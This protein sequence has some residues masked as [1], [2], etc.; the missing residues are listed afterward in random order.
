MRDGFLVIDADRHI[1]E[2]ADLWDRYMDPPFRGRVQIL[3]PGQGRR[4]VDGELVS[5]AFRLPGE[6]DTR[7]YEQYNKIFSGD[8]H[9]RSVFGEALDADFD[10]PSNLRDMDREGV[11][12][13]VLF[14]TM[15]LYII[16]KSDM[17]PQ[18]SA[19]ICR[20][21]NNWLSEYCSHDP[22]RL[23]GVMLIPLQD[24]RLAVE[25]LRRASNELGL[26]GIFWRPN[27]RSEEHTSELQ[28]RQYLVCR[29]L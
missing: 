29:L 19:A 18:V 2:P 23:K 4:L 6:G 16:W 25:E 13:S 14:P 22:T 3:G 1:I 27:P 5:D 28:S 17:D 9:Y 24:T 21:Y 8:D 20:A 15:G 11:D 26:I 12:V 7:R 10:P